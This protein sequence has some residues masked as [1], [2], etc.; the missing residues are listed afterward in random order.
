M[1]TE[2]DG[3]Q[4]VLLLSLIVIGLFLTGVVFKSASLRYPRSRVSP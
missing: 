2:M 1:D 4:K 3:E